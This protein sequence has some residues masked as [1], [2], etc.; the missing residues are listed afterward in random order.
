MV[1]GIRL[2]NVKA[3]LKFVGVITTHWPTQG[4]GGMA[5]S[6]LGATVVLTDTI[7]VLPLLR[8]NCEANLGVGGVQ[9]EEL[10]EPIADCLQ[11]IDVAGF[12]G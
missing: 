2:L 10:G 11:H 3:V 5:F 1:S 4:L 6:M 12:G 8:R 7:D 9:V